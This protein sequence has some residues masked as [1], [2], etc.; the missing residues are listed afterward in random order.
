MIAVL[1]A[2]ALLVLMALAAIDLLISR[3][4]SDE[5][6]KMGVQRKP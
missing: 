1:G 3:I 6:T 4:S 5:L 2:I